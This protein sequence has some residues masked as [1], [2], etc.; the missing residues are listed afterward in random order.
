MTSVLVTGSS[1]GIGTVVCNRLVDL[2]WNVVGCDIQP[3]PAGCAWTHHHCDLADLE[4][5]LAAANRLP[6]DLSAIIHAAAWQP[7]FRAQDYAPLDW[8]K[9]WSI[10]VASLQHFVAVAFDQ[11]CAAPAPRVLALGSVHGS[12]SS[13]QM[14]PY[15]VSKAALASYIRALAID[16][17]SSGL[18]AVNLELG[19][20]TT[21]KLHEGLRRWIDPEAAMSNLEAVIPTSTVIDPNE[22]ADVLEWLLSPS[23]RHFAGSTLP[24][25]GGVTALLASEVSPTDG[26]SIDR[27]SN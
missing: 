5:V 22:V 3:A 19:A 25:S 21:P 8:Q 4:S 12:H 26:I 1:G 16:A 9:A 13:Q 17:A 11:L 7:Q 6:D 20:T 27:A 14:A 2:G 24:Y 23:A 15:A 18:V 10:N